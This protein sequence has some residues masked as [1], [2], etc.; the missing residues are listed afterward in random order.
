MDEKET[1]TLQDPIQINYVSV[2]RLMLDKENPRF[3]GLSK[4]ASEQEILIK[5]QKEMHL[6]EL[7]DSFEKNGFYNTEPLLVIDPI[8]P[9]IN[10]S[11]LKVIVVLLLLKPC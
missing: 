2:D 10:L 4:K 11:W 5:L 1:K 3:A 6:D 8:H 9:M 7:I